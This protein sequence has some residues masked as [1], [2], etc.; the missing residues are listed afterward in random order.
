MLEELLSVALL[1]SHQTGH[2][3][4]VPQE[5]QATDQN[6]PPALEIV[7]VNAQKRK[8]PVHDV[9]ISITVLSGA[10]LDQTN[11]TNLVE[12]APLVPGFEARSGAI[13][14][15]LLTIRGI[16]TEVV[17]NSAST[18]P[19]ISVYQDGVS[20][21]R[22]PGA[23]V[24]L[25]D[26]ERVEVLKGPQGA[27]FGRSAEVGA[28]QIIQHKAGH[29]REAR[30][31]AA[32]GNLDYFELG[33]MTNV[34]LIEDTL[35]GRL[36]GVYKR[37]DGYL[38][39]TEGANPH[40]LDR[41]A[42]RGVLTYEPSDALRFD[43]IA[44]YQKDDAA[45]GSPENSVL[46][47]VNGDIGLGGAASMR[48]FGPVSGFRDFVS[49]RDLYDVSLLAHWQVSPKWHFDSISAIRSFDSAWYTDEDGTAFDL[50]GVTGFRDGD[51]WSQELRAMFQGEKRLSGFVGASFIHE[52]LFE[53]FDE[54]VD[55][56]QLLAFLDPANIPVF[57]SGNPQNLTPLIKSPPLS[58]ANAYF[59]EQYLDT[60]VNDGFDLFAEISVDLLHELNLLVGGRWSR[61]DKTRT[62]RGGA[63]QVPSTIGALGLLTGGVP[64]QTLVLPDIGFDDQIR[65]EDFDGFTWRTA[66][67][68]APSRELNLWASYSRGRRPEVIAGIF[69]GPTFGG[70]FIAPA[71]TVDSYEIGT[72]WRPPDSRVQLDGSIYHYSYENFQSMIFAGGTFE[73]VTSGLASAN[74]LEAQVAV[75]ATNNLTLFGNYAYIRARFDDRDQSGRPQVF[76]GNTFGFSPDHTF[77]VGADWRGPLPGSWTFR[78][79]PIY[80]WQSEIFFD[81]RNLP[82][83][84]QDA[85]GL[86]NISFAFGPA[87]ANWKITAAVENALDETYT[88][89]GGALSIAFGIP[90]LY[91]GPPRLWKAGFELEF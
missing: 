40:A 12:V 7:Y 48:P 39:N 87:D 37:R 55:E 49:P 34:P 33:G 6:E 52:E 28:I 70:F 2:G 13:Q 50:F 65:S 74:G 57:L 30:F 41:I 20:I 76:G 22:G 85:Y 80:S 77:A 9:P 58:L 83:F 79:T 21:S 18:D 35:F 5:S 38:S 54:E 67:K 36:A 89:M 66:L 47:A 27:L 91:L 3:P 19:R 26:V 73:T 24:D 23:V 71:E 56:R 11:T 59:L 31:H 69:E 10:F 81:E 44:N 51:Q 4:N 68:W 16:T 62:L 43:L 75:A 46:P 88:I 25:F 17:T 90:A 42:L 29:E 61:E 64:S 82:S 45:A 8:E 63:P 32:A 60:N 72:S 53:G 1:L 14:T 15:S 78:A 86:L 84:G